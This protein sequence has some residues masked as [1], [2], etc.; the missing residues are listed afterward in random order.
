MS[1]GINIR[2]NVE[3]MASALSS[4]KQSVEGNAVPVKKIIRN[5]GRDF[6]RKAGEATP[7]A[8]V[9]HSEYF[10]ATDAKDPNHQWYI[11]ESMLAG[12]ADL[13][14]KGGNWKKFKS[15]N[16][17]G[18]TQLRR[19]SV[20]KGYSRATWAGAFA[21]LGL[22]PKNAQ[23]KYPKATEGKS[24]TVQRDGASGP[25]IEIADM[26]A[27]DRFGRSTSD[28]QH[29]RIIRAGFSNAAAH[30]ASE[31]SKLLR[32]SWKKK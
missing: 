18:R 7:V 26:V 2:I 23:K 1:D 27:F 14:T 32:K 17:E 4:L 20:K 25:E 29:E 15:I 19:A 21:S 9:S 22:T 28:P 30:M 11:H 6:V 8:T 31:Y 16:K 10:L 3:E 5:A 13:R 24:Y 12:R